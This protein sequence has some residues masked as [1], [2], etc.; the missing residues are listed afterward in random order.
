MIPII[1]SPGAQ[2]Y[3]YCIVS[4]RR[5]WRYAC[6]QIIEMFQNIDYERFLYCIKWTQA[7]YRNTIRRLTTDVNPGLS[8][9]CLLRHD[10]GAVQAACATERTSE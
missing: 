5:L 6:K 4:Y 3:Y 7:S 10:S 9:R 2:T 8:D 1:R